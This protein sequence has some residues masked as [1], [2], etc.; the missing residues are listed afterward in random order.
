[1]NDK[2][3]YK[4]LRKH[5]GASYHI[6]HSFKT[7]SN[8]TIKTIEDKEIIDL[9]AGY[10]VVNIGYQHPKMVEYQKTL[11]DKIN[12]VPTWMC[13]TEVNEL[14]EKLRSFFPNTNYQCLK[15]SGGSNGNEVAISVFYN[16]CGGHIGT[17]ERSYHGWSQTTLG[18]G[19]IVSY[20]LPNVRPEY[21]TKKL[22]PPNK[23]TIREVESFFDLNPEIKIFI[24]E[25]ILG[26]GGVLFPD[27][28]FYKEFYRVC[29]ERGVYLIFDETITAFGRIGHMFCSHY[30]GIDPDGII[31]AK[32]MSSGYAAI[33]TVMIKEEIMKS[34]KFGDVSATF[35]WIPSACG[36]T[37]KNIEIIE[38]EDL[39]NNSK[40][41]GEYFKNTLIDLFKDFNTPIEV[42]GIGLMI[43][44]QFLT[45]N[46]VY[47]TG[48]VVYDLIENGVMFCY[49]GDN[50]SIVALPPLTIDKEGID[51]CVDII[52]EV[53]I[54]RSL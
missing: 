24:A 9:S 4:S 1:M 45:P 17:F 6:P 41:M 15:T 11:I 28:G 13:T 21:I 39:C 22:P 25:P 36:I 31:L 33:G 3:L 46:R 52:R 48:R 50:D 12:Y 29:K 30:Y 35:S 54:K 19:D 18:M 5:I 53:F 38:E 2:Q 42:R 10:G 20:K 23:L 7:A 44:I 26:S 34:Y 16:L 37:K 32:G 27:K 8:Y 51:K 47:L 49:S 43:G 40:V 14:Q